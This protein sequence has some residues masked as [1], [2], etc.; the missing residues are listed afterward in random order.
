MFELLRKSEKVLLLKDADAFWAHC[1]NTQR[2]RHSRPGEEAAAEERL[3]L[4]AANKIKALLEAEV[5]PEEGATPVQCQ[6]WDWND[7][8]VRSVVIL[9]GA[10]KRD[11][12]AKLQGLLTGDF[13]DFSIIVTLRDD[14]GDDEAW[15]CMKI[16]A[17]RIAMQRHV[18]QAYALVP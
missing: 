18:A 9:R 4:R 17:R 13:A 12:V 1:D 3:D 14:W 2:R 16:S 5:G 8:R 10:F 7:D 15:G 6:V 11:V